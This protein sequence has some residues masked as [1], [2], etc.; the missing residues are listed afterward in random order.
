MLHFELASK[1]YNNHGKSRLDNGKWE[2]ESALQ[3]SGG[4]SHT[5]MERA[6]VAGP[7]IDE[8]FE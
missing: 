4:G 3:E 6:P 2:R 8:S 1:T 7:E 5:A